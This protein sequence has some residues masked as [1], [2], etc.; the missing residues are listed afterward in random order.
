MS[1]KDDEQK[2]KDSKDN[3]LMMPGVTDPNPDKTKQAIEAG[4]RLKENIHLMV[5]FFEINAKLTRAKFDALK[6]EGF[7]DAQALELCQT[8][9]KEGG[10]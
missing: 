3:V 9:F 5:E 8:L 4:N 6:K 1:D 2:G 7:T 10:P